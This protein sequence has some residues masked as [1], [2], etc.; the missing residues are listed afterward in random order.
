MCNALRRDCC[1]AGATNPD[2]GRLVVCRSVRSI[3]DPAGLQLLHQAINRAL[4]D[5]CRWV[6]SHTAQ[7]GAFEAGVKRMI[8]LTDQASCMQS[9]EGKKK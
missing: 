7:R 2:G 1:E 3:C 5:R 6:V 4:R 9:I 8:E